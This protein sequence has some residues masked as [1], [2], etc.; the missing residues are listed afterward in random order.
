MDLVA[1]SIAAGD[2]FSETTKFVSKLSSDYPE[3]QIPVLQAVT[4]FLKG[5]D[6]RILPG[7]AP[8]P[9]FLRKEPRS[10]NF[11]QP[12]TAFHLGL[13]LKNALDMKVLEWVDGCPSP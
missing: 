3:A 12:A 6:G 7:C 10:F 1:R 8:L 2:N 5:S 4:V 13:G 9:T 11:K